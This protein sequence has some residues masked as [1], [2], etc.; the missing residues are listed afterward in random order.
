M[1]G[2]YNQTDTHITS[3][4]EI[5]TLSTKCTPDKQQ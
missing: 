4:L 3:A 2:E 1:D 5:E